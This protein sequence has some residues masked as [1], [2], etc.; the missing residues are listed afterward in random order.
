MRTIEV[1]DERRV[2]LTPPGDGDAGKQPGRHDGRSTAVFDGR[3]RVGN[4]VSFFVDA[5]LWGLLPYYRESG[6]L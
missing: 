5:A 4:R 1:E 3:R 6:H 2:L